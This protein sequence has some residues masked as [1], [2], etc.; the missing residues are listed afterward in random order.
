[1]ELSDLATTDLLLPAA[2]LGGIALITALGGKK[3]GILASGRM[4][5]G[6]ELMAAKRLAL[7]LMKARRSNEVAGQINRRLYLPELERGTVI[8]GKPKVGKSSIIEP[9]ARSLLRQGFPMILFDHKYPDQSEVLAGYAIEQGY[10]VSVFAP[11]LPESC[12]V[13]PLDFLCDETD[14]VMA[15]EVATVIN[16]NFTLASSKGTDPFFGES[17][18]Q[19]IEAILLL[20]KSSKYPDLVMAQKLL[21][22]EDIVARL[23][24][25]DLNPWVRTSFDQFISLAKSEKT[26]ASIAGTAL[27]FF[28]R[29]VK[30]G[31][32][33]SFVGQTTLP[34]KLEGKRL[35][36]LG[37]DPRYSSVVTPL[38]AT[39]IHLLVILNCAQ[40]R[41]DPLIFLGDEIPTINLPDLS[42]W[43][44]TKRSKGF[45][46]ILGAQNYPL[47]DDAIGKDKRRAICSAAGTLISFNPGDFETARDLSDICGE[48]QVDFRQR[49]SGSSGGK[50]SS[51]VS[52]QSQI[53]KLVEPA[54]LLK[55]GTGRALLRIPAA[56]SRDDSY[57]PVITKIHLEKNDQADAA[58]SRE[59]WTRLRAKLVERNKRPAITGDALQERAIAANELIHLPELDEIV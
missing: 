19:L 25:N 43:I 44:N 11:G 51:N 42:K 49:S 15:R 38:L 48:K 17:G 36:I 35:I 31:I 3:K 28:S 10:Q 8:I 57:L 23:K 4:G 5:G 9:L 24:A 45:C 12:V 59:L 54:K 22:L 14:G 7:R 18:D 30:P 21:G 1:M 52:E 34:L 32:V 50:G 53:V 2:V 37:L 13:N 39:V 58:R 6:A 55:L 33:N 29:F 56:Q 46:P 47:W 20:A 26:A 40:R 41:T 16:K 27:I